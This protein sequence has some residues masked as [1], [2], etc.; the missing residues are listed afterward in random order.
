MKTKWIALATLI[1]A[2]AVGLPWTSVA[3]PADRAEP[4]VSPIHLVLEPGASQTRPA[5]DSASALAGGWE[6]IKTEYFES[7]FPNDWHLRGDPTWGR[8]RDTDAAYPELAQ[9]TGWCAGGGSAALS[10]G[11]LPGGEYAPNMNSWMIYG[12]FSLKGCSNGRVEFKYWLWS[13]YPADWL[14]WSASKDG[15]NFHNLG[16]TG[17]DKTWRSETFWLDDVP[18]LGHLGGKRRV[19]IAF[20][21]ASDGDDEYK[22]AYLDDIEIMRFRSDSPVNVSVDPETFLAYAGATYFFTTTWRD[23]NHWTELKKFYLH[24]GTSP[25]LANNVT[26]LYNRAAN[27]VWLRNDAGTAWLGGLQM[28][29]PGLIENSQ[30][31][32]FPGSMSWWNGTDEHS[33]T[34]QW[35]MGFTPA[36]TGVKK[37]GMKAIDRWGAKAPG[38]WM[39]TWTILNP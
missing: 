15:V 17:E 26:L 9:W 7:A 6:T 35:V 4:E 21:F 29:R 18:A 32:V 23:P 27:T 2:V 39:G 24:F 28:G 22:G 36:F 5:R 13:E 31:Y 3:D 16:A 14:L 33:V 34:I 30:A 25:S 8:E 1:I 38:Q 11:P 19:W 20:A 12:P 37:V 10:P